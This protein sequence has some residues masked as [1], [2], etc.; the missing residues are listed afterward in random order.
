MHNSLNLPTIPC[1]HLL[2][3]ENAASGEKCVD[4]SL[5]VEM[6]YLATVPN[7]YEIAC[8]ITGDKDFIPVLQ[9]TRLLG[10]YS[11]F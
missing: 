5:A 4:I 3:Y 2:R 9:K 1:A 7:A 10:M 6:L 11:W 8:I